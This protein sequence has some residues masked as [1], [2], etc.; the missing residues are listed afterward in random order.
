M[1][2]HTVDRL[3]K[4]LY[5]VAHNKVLCVGRNYVN[6]AIEMKS[7]IPKEPIIFDKVLTSTI[8]S[9]DLLYLKRNNEIHHEVELGVLIGMTG[10]NIKAEN[11]EQHVEGYFIGID[12]TDRDLQSRAKKNGT[13]W[14]IS[15]CQD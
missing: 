13:P 8:R 5:N 3:Y 4:S 6:H 11:W 1:S 15:K 10:K 7:E 14:T 9:G 2:T 12:F